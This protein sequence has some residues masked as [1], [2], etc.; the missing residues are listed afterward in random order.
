MSLSMKNFDFPINNLK[1]DCGKCQ[2]ART[3]WFWDAASHIY[4]SNTFYPYSTRM[5][6]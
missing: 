2:V 5:K 4:C 3:A 6:L 1:V